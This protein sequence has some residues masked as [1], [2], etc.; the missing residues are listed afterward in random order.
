MTKT[1]KKLSFAALA[2][3]GLGLQSSFAQ[4]DTKTDN[5]TVGITIP[6]VALLDLELST[7]KDI[8]MAFTAPSP[9]EAGNPIVA[10]ANNTSLWLNYSSIVEATG[11][12][13][14][15][16]VT[17]KTSATIPGVSIKVTAGADAGAGAGTK[18]T[19]VAGGVTLTTS[20]QDLI[21]GVGSCWT[22]TG[23][24]KGHQLTYALSLTSAATYGSL[25]A[26]TTTVTVTYTL[27]AD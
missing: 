20:D 4:T 18:G 9:S 13:V 25:V 3:I 12:D 21:T 15:R 8:T 6:E 23:T 11:A 27:S 10:P 7:S 16:K 24:S 22:D 17:V 19:V 14:A 5:H 26:G 1:M 2:I